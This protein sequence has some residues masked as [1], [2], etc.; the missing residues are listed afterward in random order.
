MSPGCFPKNK[1]KD[2]TYCSTLFLKNEHER[3]RILRTPTEERR[4][5]TNIFLDPINFSGG[6]QI[7]LG[8][9]LLDKFELELRYFAD[10]GPKKGTSFSKFAQHF[11]LLGSYY[12]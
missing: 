10:S 1:R 12:F 9:L 11:A 6:Y 2:N 4:S 8:A 5:T 3:L 7:G